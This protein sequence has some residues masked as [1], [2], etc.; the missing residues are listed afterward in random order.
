MH[1]HV[2]HKQKQ[3]GL[4]MHMYARVNAHTLAA[5]SS[6]TAPIKACVISE[7]AAMKS[8]PRAHLFKRGNNEFFVAS[9]LPITINLAFCRYVHSDPYCI[10]FWSGASHVQML[11]GQQIYSLPP[12]QC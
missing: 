10:G 12:R 6:P 1:V 7:L 9:H 3:R 8:Q 2:R 11:C 4:H 5:H